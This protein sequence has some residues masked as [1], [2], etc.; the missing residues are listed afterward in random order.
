MLISPLRV[1]P[2]FADLKPAEVADLW[3]LA[4]KVS[5]CMQ[6]HYKADA[7]SLV[8]QVLFRQCGLS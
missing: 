4:Q 6:T 8:I 2:K 7:M 3:Q 1:E 5:A